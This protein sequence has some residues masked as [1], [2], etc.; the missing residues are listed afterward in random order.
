METNW[1][2]KSVKVIDHQ[3]HTKRKNELYNILGKCNIFPRKMHVGVGVFYPII[4]EEDLEDM[5]KEETV[6]KI[7][8]KGFEIITPIEFGAMKTIVIKEID[9]MIDDFEIDEIKNSIEDLN[10][11]ARV[12][13]VI[14]MPTTSKMLKIQF[15]STQMVQQAL[16]EGVVVLY[17]KIPPRRIEKEIFVRVQPCN[18]CFGY[19]HETKNCT[20]RKMT[21]CAFCGE[22][23]HKQQQCKSETPKCIN[24]GENHKTLAAKC[25][26]RKNIIKEK[27]KQIRDRSKSRGRSQTRQGAEFQ[28]GITY[29]NM[30][31]RYNQGGREQQGITSA[32][33][34]KN[35]TAVILSAVIYSQYM[36]T[37]IPGSFQQNMNIIY[38]KNGLNPVKFLEQIPVTGMSD[39]YKDVLKSQLSKEAEGTERE[40]NVEDQ[41]T[42]ITSEM[43]TESTSKRT[44]ETSTSPQETLETKKK[45]EA[46]MM[47]KHKL[48]LTPQERPPLPPPPQPQPQRVQRKDKTELRPQGKAAEEREIEREIQKARLAASTR[49]RTS[50]QSSTTSVSSVGSG[51]TK[52]SR[53]MQITVYVM[54]NEHNRKLFSRKLR[55]ED[56][57][58]IVKCLTTGIAKITWDHPNIKREA[59]VQAILEGIIST[60]KITFRMVKKE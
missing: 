40:D 19:S 34:L 51:T 36:E 31:G 32:E 24:C 60:D 37:I 35:L 33:E 59:L 8:E 17:Q 5:L 56:K 20:I 46:Q 28:Q 27:R 7:K 57:Q 45:K 2:Q 14:K 4:N 23:G 52:I 16:K 55:A 39:I 12:R 54:E 48:K 42:D 50:S 49:P 30:T 26:I 18:N 1:K 22:E 6:Q 47:E 44:R 9:S 3:P 25:Q 29:A 21:L 58:N 11:W 15:S 38:K 53:E 41:G 10:P 43:E 13:E